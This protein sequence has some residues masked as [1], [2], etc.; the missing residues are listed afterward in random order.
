MS[1]PASR[2][3]RFI[4][5]LRFH[6]FHRRHFSQQHDTAA[7]LSLSSSVGLFPLLLDQ[8]QSARKL[9]I[10]HLTFLLLLLLPSMNFLKN[11][12][13]LLPHYLFAFSPS[14]TLSSSSLFN[15][16]INFFAFIFNSFLFS[17]S[18]TQHRTT[19]TDT[20]GNAE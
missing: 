4:P 7:L 9:I 3:L 1:C 13:P 10:L 15:F 5:L 2:L 12:F 19:H 16:F 17:S 11:L 20:H 6:P 8:F 18:S 14:A